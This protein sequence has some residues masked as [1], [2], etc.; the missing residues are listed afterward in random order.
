MEIN[1]IRPFF[2]KGMSVL[3]KLIRDPEHPPKLDEI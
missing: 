2:I 1:E 3:T